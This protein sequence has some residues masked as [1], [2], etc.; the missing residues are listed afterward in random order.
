MKRI[1]LSLVLLGTSALNITNAAEGNI[2]AGKTKSA[3]CAACHGVD[4]NSLVPMYPSLAGQSASYIA[5]QLADFKTGM[6]SGGKSGRVDPIMGGM[7]MALNEQDMNDLGAYFN[8]QMAKT[9]GG[10]T[11]DIG[12]KLYFGGDVERGITACIACHS[13]DA[14]G[15]SHAGFPAV[16][17]QSA[18]Y[19]KS[20]LEK[21]RDGARSNDKNAMMQNIAF[22]LEDADIT[23]LVKYMSTI[24]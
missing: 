4:G 11:S 2:D 23:A 12:K 16:G 6:T 19:L 1:L 18:I 8:A 24:K 21:F 3:M 7:T 20:Q 15:M 17:G 14:K 9:A 10:E 13:S 22:K 5:K